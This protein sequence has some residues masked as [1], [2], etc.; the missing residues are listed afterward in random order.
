MCVHSYVCALATQFTMLVMCQDMIGY[1]LM[2]LCHLYLR[3][4]AVNVGI[5]YVY[6]AF[7]QQIDA[8]SYG[9]TWELTKEGMMGAFAL[10]LVCPPS[11]R[12]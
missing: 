6:Y 4:F 9:G 8:E 11:P 2:C 10:F 3:F 5:V 7:Y 1:S 12:K